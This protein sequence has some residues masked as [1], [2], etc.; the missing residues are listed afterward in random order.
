LSNDA[1]TAAKSKNIEIFTVGFGLDAASGGDPTCPDTSGA[2]NGK[3]ATALLASMST[4]PTNGT[5]TC[6][7]AENTDDD[8]FLCIS[9]SGP[10]NELSNIFKAAAASLAKGRSR[11]IQLYP[12]P[13]LKAI[14]P[15]AGTY[16]GGTTVTITGQYFSGAT[17]VKFGGTSAAFTVVSD[18]AISAKAPAGKQ[19]VTVDI[20]VST[21][22][23]STTITSADR[24]TYN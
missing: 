2:W 11:L 8:H 7:A 1:A 22:G 14:S 16:L 13:D 6:T 20:V 23:G 19:G 12:V 21:P 17:S 18:T 24:F 15:N 9:K 10:S 4:Q 5:T 3:T